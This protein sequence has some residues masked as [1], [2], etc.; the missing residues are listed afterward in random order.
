[1]NLI[2]TKK[3]L[4][5]WL[6]FLYCDF[7]LLKNF[8][9]TASDIIKLAFYK[10]NFHFLLVRI[11]EAPARSNITTIIFVFSRDV[12]VEVY[13]LNRTFGFS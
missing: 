6:N 2:K 7:N 3:S 5:E 9:S 10:S 12:F 1:M 4:L 11:A 8:K 13:L